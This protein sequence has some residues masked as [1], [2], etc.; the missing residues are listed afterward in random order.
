MKGGKITNEDKRFGKMLGI[1]L[2]RWVGCGH[3]YMMK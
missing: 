2:L 3:A 1:C